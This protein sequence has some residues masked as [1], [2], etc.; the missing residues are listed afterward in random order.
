M[1]APFLLHLCMYKCKTG[2]D[3]DASPHPLCRSC[4]YDAGSV[5]CVM[6]LKVHEFLAVQLHALMTVQV[7]KSSGEPGSQTPELNEE[8]EP[9][10]C[11][12]SVSARQSA[13]R[14]F[15]GVSGERLSPPNL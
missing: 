13:P 4:D 10:R 5:Q 15:R 3:Q 8:T 9:P 11:T 1:Y 7:Q 2:N 6:R 14:P 12:T